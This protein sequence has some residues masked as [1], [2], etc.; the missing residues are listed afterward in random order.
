MLN[1]FLLYILFTSPYFFFSLFFFFV[2]YSRKM[3]YNAIR[4]R[5]KRFRLRNRYQYQWFRPI[6]SADT[7]FRSDTTL[8]SSNRGR[9]RLQTMVIVGPPPLM[10][11]RDTRCRTWSSPSIG[12]ILRVEVAYLWAGIMGVTDI[13]WRFAMLRAMTVSMQPVS[14]YTLELNWRKLCL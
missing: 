2:C 8:R 6:L 13:F 7:E 11:V 10:S 4:L 9:F 14:G 3:Q 5:L 12:V 1:S